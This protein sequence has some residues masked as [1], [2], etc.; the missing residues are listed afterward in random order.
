MQYTVEMVVHTV[1]KAVLKKRKKTKH[2]YCE[3]VGQFHLCSIHV[4]VYCMYHVYKSGLGTNSRGG[5]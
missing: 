4:T 3:S 1:Q 2:M 5:G